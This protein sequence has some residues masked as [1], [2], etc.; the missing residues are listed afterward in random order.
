[1][2]DAVIEIVPY[3][4][5]NVLQSD[6][7]QHNTTYSSKNPRHTLSFRYSKLFK[8]IAST[9]FLLAVVSYSYFST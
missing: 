8:M 4:L 7:A 3:V 9:I 2:S 6:F 1:M 5:I